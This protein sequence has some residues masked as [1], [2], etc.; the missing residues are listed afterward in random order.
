MASDRQG[1]LYCQHALG[2]HGT[3]VIV[4]PIT[5]VPCVP[6]SLDTVTRDQIP[7]K[8]VCTSHSANTLWVNSR[9][10]WIFNFGM[11]TNPGEG[12]LL[13]ICCILLVVK[14]LSEYTQVKLDKNQSIN[15]TNRKTK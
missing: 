8:A 10:D 12:K 13:G 9:A 15:N 11:A 5:I 3:M 7:N 2:T 4:E 1:N 6:P 14:G